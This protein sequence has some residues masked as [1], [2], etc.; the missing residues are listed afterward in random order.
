MAIRRT[1]RTRRKRCK[2]RAR[3]MSGARIRLRTS[4]GRL[5]HGLVL[6][7]VTINGGGYGLIIT[8]IRPQLPEW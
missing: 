2:I 1:R 8:R 7:H 5:Y 3:I 6:G 4:A